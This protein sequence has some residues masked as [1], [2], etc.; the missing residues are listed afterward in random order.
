MK[1]YRCSF[2][3]FPGRYAGYERVNQP[4]HAFETP[5]ANYSLWTRDERKVRL[6]GMYSLTGCSDLACCD[7]NWLR[8]VRTG[9]GIRSFALSAADCVHGCPITFQLNGASV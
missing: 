5:R 7:W 1:Y 8:H 6:P 9:L 4:P 3:I 2:E